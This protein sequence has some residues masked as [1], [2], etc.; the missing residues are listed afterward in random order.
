MRVA[1]AFIHAR[2]RASPAYAS[3]RGATRSSWARAVTATCAQPHNSHLP[4]LASPHLRS[5][6]PYTSTYLLPRHSFR[7]LAFHCR[8]W[9][10][11]PAYFYL[12]ITIKKAEARD[13]LFCNSQQPVSKVGHLMA[14]IVAR[15]ATE[16]NTE[17]HPCVV[18]QPQKLPHAAH[19]RAFGFGPPQQVSSGADGRRGSVMLVAGACSGWSGAGR[20]G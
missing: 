1:N 20:V 10:R 2:A 13:R 12:E 14:T 6:C 4:T 17:H 11:Y 7:G 5:H 8:R 19:Y 18:A 16:F 9:Y 3:A 15:H